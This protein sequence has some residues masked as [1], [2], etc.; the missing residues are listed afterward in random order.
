MVCGIGIAAAFSASQTASR[1]RV[2]CALIR[3]ET[4]RKESRPCIISGPDYQKTAYTRS[5]TGTSAATVV[6]RL[7]TWADRSKVGTE[8]MNKTEERCGGQW[9]P[10]EEN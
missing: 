6:C 2:R 5:P 1:C 3:S 8:T 4:A 7:P 9:W 10:E